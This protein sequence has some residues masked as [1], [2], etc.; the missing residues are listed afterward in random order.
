[1]NEYR[2]NKNMWPWVLFR[3]LLSAQIK[4]STATMQGVEWKKTKLFGEMKE[5]QV[6]NIARHTSKKV[7]STGK[8]VLLFW[9]GKK[10]KTKA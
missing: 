8:C 1:M 2:K 4:L 10:S 5:I 7:H 6:S 3:I 9:K